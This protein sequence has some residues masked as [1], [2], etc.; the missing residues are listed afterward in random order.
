[1]PFM[2]DDD[3]IDAA[4]WAAGALTAPE[5]HAVKERLKRDP[6]FA[7]KAREWE[8]ALTPLAACVGAV[9]P[10]ADLL[11][12][13]ETRLDARVKLESLSRTLRANEGEWITLVN[14]VRFK[15]LHRNEALSRW[16]I[17]IEAD[18]GASF[19]PH[20]HPQDEEIY[21]ISGDLCIGDLELGAGDFHFAPKGSR[22][23]ENRTRGG[24]RCI[25]VQAM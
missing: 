2:S 20:D 15:E 14:G 8:E 3:D 12:S 13:I 6:G 24:C 19:P 16:T 18:P 23:P 21:V 10:P 9:A 17:L 22:H 4:L 5:Y 1:M 11:G 7:A 25:F